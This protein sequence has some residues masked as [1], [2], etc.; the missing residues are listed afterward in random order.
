M[1]IINKKAIFLVDLPDGYDA[2]EVLFDYVLTTKGEYKVLR[3]GGNHEVRPMPEKMTLNR[4]M[5]VGYGI[6]YRNGWNDCID[7]IE[8]EILGE[9]E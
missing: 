5:N 1:L 7:C 4:T 8:D 9:T 6:D 2:D 3:K